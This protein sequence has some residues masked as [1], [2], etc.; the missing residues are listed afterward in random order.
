MNLTYEALS[1]ELHER[2]PQL[3]EQKYTGLIGK[4]NVD[5]EPFALYGVVFNHFLIELSTT[6][7]DESK[8]N[9]AA[10][11]EE[12]ATSSDS[13]VVFLLTS[14]LLPTLVKDQGT[15]DAYWP[16][17]G[18]QTRRRA[19]LLPPKFLRNVNLPSAG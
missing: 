17:L 19:S 11:L 15:V 13:H 18:P 4:I 6:R 2:F 14:E 9:A 16:L 8:K 5:T 1:S 7:D 10:F 3:A 12:M